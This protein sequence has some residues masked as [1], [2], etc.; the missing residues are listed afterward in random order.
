MIPCIDATTPTRVTIKQN[1]LSSFILIHIQEYL[2]TLACFK[3]ISIGKYTV[4]GKNDMAPN[5]PTML[6]KNGNIIA[7]KVVIIT[8]TVLHITLNMFILHVPTNGILALYSCVINLLC[9]QR[10]LTQLSTMENIG[11]ANTCI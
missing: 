7:I 8:Y 6:L 10:L 9:G 5:R 2:G 1:P 11:C 4:K 3:Y